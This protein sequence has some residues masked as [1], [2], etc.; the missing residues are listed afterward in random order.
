MAEFRRGKF[1]GSIKQQLAKSRTEQVGPPHDFGDPHGGIVDHDRELIGRHLIFAPD[2]EIA[3]VDP[4][5]GALPP[6][7]A[8]DERQF[9]AGRDPKAPGRSGR[10][11]ERW[12][13]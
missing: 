2:D 4:G 11:G 1:Q 6:G 3:E 12:N 7:P 13:R 9:F 5:R 10:I 8:V